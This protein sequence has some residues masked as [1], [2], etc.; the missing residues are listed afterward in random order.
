MFSRVE[1]LL[2]IPLALAALVALLIPAVGHAAAGPGKPA[3]AFTLPSADGK[4]V[5]LSDFKGKVVVLE[6]TNAGCPFVRKHYDSG[7]MQALQKRWT[8]QGVVWLTI[9]S[10]AEG[11]QGHVDAAAARKEIAD[12]KAQPTAYLLDHDGKVG[13]AYGAKATPHMFVIDAEGKMVYTGAIDDKR[14]ANVD[15]IPR[16]KNLVSA[17]LE[18]VLAGQPVKAPA[19]L[20]YGCAMKYADAD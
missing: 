8:E 10:S 16:A 5:S 14:S 2:S 19:T 12:N 1:R 20:P 15:D 11:K 9:N 18:A 13:K 3:P 6:W 4:Q 17:A 7:N